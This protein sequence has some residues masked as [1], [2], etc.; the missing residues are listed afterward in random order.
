[1]AYQAASE[2]ARH[3]RA[4]YPD[5][6]YK[7]SGGIHEIKHDGYRLIARDPLRLRL[8]CAPREDWRPRPL[9]ARKA[10]LA[11]LL[12]KAPAGLQYT[13]HLERDGAAIFAHAC[14]LGAEGIV[15]KHRDHPYRSGRSKAWIKTKNLAAPWDAA[16]SG[17]AMAGEPDQIFRAALY[18]DY[19]A[20]NAEHREERDQY[21]SLAQEFRNCAAK[22]ST[23]LAFE[24]PKR[25]VAPS[26]RRDA[27]GRRRERR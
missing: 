8:A 15:S 26:I 21:L 27:A 13:E 12:A 11:K 20:A 18:C 17:G 9:E 25:P 4:L 5:P 22:E 7:A 14:R 24:M 16:V 2:A 23:R 10:R 19:R 6:S 3:D 1:V